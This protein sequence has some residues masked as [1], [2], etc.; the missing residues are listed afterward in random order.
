[1]VDE[2]A[3][4]NVFASDSDDDND[5]DDGSFFAFDRPEDLDMDENENDAFEK[6]VSGG[7]AAVAA[8]NNLL[9][10]NES[11]ENAPGADR[12]DEHPVMSGGYDDDEADFNTFDSGAGATEDDATTASTFVVGSAQQ[13]KQT[14][15]TI[16][17][18][19]EEVE[20]EVLEDV[21]DPW[22]T[23]DPHDPNPFGASSSKAGVNLERP[24]KKGIPYRIPQA[25]KDLM[26]E[27]EGK[28]P[29][30]KNAKQSIK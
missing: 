1:V 3:Q 9:N 14:K 7:V 30:R 4:P 29:K 13:Q 26:E 10:L 24:L 17:T 8:A 15:K 6:E 27:N 25:L 19:E 22:A 21:K 20:E 18:Q 2:S 11:D 28:K 16:V 23:L 12:D 5:R